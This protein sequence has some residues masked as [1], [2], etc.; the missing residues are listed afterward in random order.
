MFM[1]AYSIGPMGVI[2][3]DP[4]IA[5][6][7]AKLLARA[8]K[9][10]VLVDSSKFGSRGNLVVCGLADID[11]LITDDAAPPEML[12][13]VRSAGVEVRVVTATPDP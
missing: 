4:L 9:L 13:I 1:S 2:E 5:R 10:I 6:A 8:E 7:E 3:G 11:T 12:D